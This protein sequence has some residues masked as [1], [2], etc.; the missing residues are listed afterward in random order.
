[1]RLYAVHGIRVSGQCN[2]PAV[3]CW[4]EKVADLFA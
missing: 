1:M 4:G 2:V 3:L